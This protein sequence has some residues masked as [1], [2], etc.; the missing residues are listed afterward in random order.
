MIPIAII[1]PETILKE[2]DSKYFLILLVPPDGR[3]CMYTGS[4]F[5]VYGVSGEFIGPI[6][7]KAFSREG[8]SKQY[9]NA[10]EITRRA[11]M[12]GSLKIIEIPIT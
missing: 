7:I 4:G 1:D 8:L 6:D 2:S 10:L 3:P 9:E 5:D 12:E 11:R